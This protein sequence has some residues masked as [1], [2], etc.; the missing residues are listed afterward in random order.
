MIYYWNDYSACN[1]RA[2]TVGK[3]H[4]PYFEA[5]KHTIETKCAQ[6]KSHTHTETESAHPHTHKR[7]VEGAMGHMI[8]G[9][10]KRRSRCEPP[11][12]P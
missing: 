6:Q 1:P 7:A 10:K 11:S 2:D 3:P 5:P 4:D 8:E 12:D 9:D